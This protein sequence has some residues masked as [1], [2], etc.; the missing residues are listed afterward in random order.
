LP[1]E[2]PPA[3]ISARVLREAAARA[4][5]QRRGLGTWISAWMTGA[6]WRA[7][8]HPAAAAV[9]SLV[10]VAGVAGALFARDRLEMATPRVESAAVYRDDARAGT[11]QVAGVTGGTESRAATASPAAEAVPPSEMAMEHDDERR[12]RLSSD[13]RAQ[14]GEDKSVAER[15]RRTLPAKPTQRADRE[16]ERD[17]AARA[18][19]AEE[20]AAFLAQDVADQA[21]LERPADPGE[22]YRGGSGGAGKE[23]FAQAPEAVAP[24]QK[25]AVTPPG[26]DASEHAQPPVASSI[27]TGTAEAKPRAESWAES[28]HA[29]LRVALRDQQCTRAVG[30]ADDIQTREPGYYRAQ[31]ARSKELAACRTAGRKAAN[32]DGK[33]RD[34]ASKRAADAPKADGSTNAE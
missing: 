8:V 13:T 24:S 11:G 12:D 18:G 23:A 30:I 4:T 10:L 6:L 7:W 32:R 9:A 20:Q 31:L 19:D 26:L 1:E 16:V 5:Q 34:Q 2:E 21:L 28:R 27:A 33:P 22:G 29:E 15:A 17:L 25:A 3:A 14:L